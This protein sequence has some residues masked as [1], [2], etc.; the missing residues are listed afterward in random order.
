MAEI[1][2]RRLPVLDRN[3]RLV[4]ILSLCDLAAVA[5][6]LD[7]AEAL[8]GISRPARDVVMDVPASYLDGN[9]TM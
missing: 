6:A 2:V 4:G 3:K 5:P 1:Q 9:R 8:A 7:I